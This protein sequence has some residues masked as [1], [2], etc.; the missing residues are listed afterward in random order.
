MLLVC[1]SRLPLPRCISR[2]AIDLLEFA[3]PYPTQRRICSL[4]D[5]NASFE[6]QTIPTRGT[7]STFGTLVAVRRR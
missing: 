7:P 5:H 6:A 1:L 4:S 2:K 3:F